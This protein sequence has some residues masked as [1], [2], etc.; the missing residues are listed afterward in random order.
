MWACGCVSSALASSFASYHHII[1][2]SITSNIIL[3]RWHELNMKSTFG[4]CFI[5][6]ENVL[7]H[8][9]SWEIQLH[10]LY[11]KRRDPLFTKLG[12]SYKAWI[13]SRSMDIFLYEAWKEGKVFFRRRLKNCMYVKVSCI[14]N[15][16]ITNSLQIR[17][18][19]IHIEYYSLVAAKFRWSSKN[20]FTKSTSPPSGPSPQLHLAIC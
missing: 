13:F 15:K 14:A 10:Q 5:K 16:W 2:H 11:C 4:D 7:R 1:P 3:H 20:V 12:C 19:I 6:N 8:K 9:V 18:K 17:F